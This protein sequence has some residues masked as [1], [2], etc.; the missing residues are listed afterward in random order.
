MEDGEGFGSDAF[1]QFAV[2]LVEAKYVFF[3]ESRPDTATRA[4]AATPAFAWEGNRLVVI[5]HRAKIEIVLRP[6]GH[7]R[8]YTAPVRR[9][10]LRVETQDQSL[11]LTCHGV[12]TRQPREVAG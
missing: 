3:V 6:C 1:Q 5:E 2:I 10:P 9:R 11:R 7:R 12:E 8:N 4:N